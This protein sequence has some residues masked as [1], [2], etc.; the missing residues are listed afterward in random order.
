MKK[1]Y[2]AIYVATVAICFLVVVGFWF[3]VGLFLG[4]EATSRF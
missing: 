2:E 1:L 4:M 3:G